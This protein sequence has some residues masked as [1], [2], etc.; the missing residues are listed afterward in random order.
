MRF[1]VI[2]LFLNCLLFAQNDPHI[3]DVEYDEDRASGTLHIITDEPEARIFVNG[4]AAGTGSLVL[5]D[6]PLDR[7]EIYA[8]HEDITITENVFVLQDAV[9]TVDISLRRSVHVNI[10]TSY[11]HMWSEGVSAYGPGLQLEIQHRK[12]LY[13]IN[14]NWDF[15]ATEVLHMNDRSQGF[16]LG[17]AAFTWHYVV[18]DLKGI[19]YIAPGISSG[20]WY[21]DGSK[22][23]PKQRDHVD[24]GY[25]DH[26]YY[27]D[28]EHF[29]NYFFGGPSVNA[30]V[31]YRAANFS[32][33]YALLL[34]TGFGHL[35]TVG[36]RLRI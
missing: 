15:V 5:E 36:F 10:T 12:S 21:F 24:Y 28:Y 32:V 1:P 4:K 9:R 17:G 7:Y 14:Y 33:S 35:L 34:G 26:Y 27:D 2:V 13:G 20:F 19:F 31:G 11:S 22:Y 3:I 18:V 16:A 29:E 23:A 30:W 25:Y 6:L 8:T